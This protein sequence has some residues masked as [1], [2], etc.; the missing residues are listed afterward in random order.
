MFDPS[1]FSFGNGLFY[2]PVT[3]S[4]APVVS[5]AKVKGREYSL[6]DYENLKYEIAKQ[7][8][9]L[10]VNHQASFSKSQDEI[11]DDMA[12]QLASY[13]VSSLADLKENKYTVEE[14]DPYY[15]DD[16]EAPVVTVEKKDVIN[17]KTGEVI[18]LNELNNAAGKGFTWY[19]I[20]FV[21]G[22]AV[23]YAW[24]E[25]TGAGA[26]GDQIQSIVSIPPIA[27]AL[28][29]ATAGA[30]QPTAKDI[31]TSL[32]PE[33]ASQAAIRAATNAIAN[34]GATT[35]VV[36]TATGDLGQGLQAGAA[37]LLQSGINQLKNQGIN[38]L[39]QATGIDLSVPKATGSLLDTGADSTDYSFLDT[40]TQPAP[41]VAPVTTD[42][43]DFNTDVE[44]QV[45]G[46]YGNS[47]TAEYDPRLQGTYL[48]V[49]GKDVFIP[50]VVAP[51]ES[52]IVLSTTEAAPSLLDVAPA[53]IFSS[54]LSPTTTPTLTVVANKPTVT[55]LGAVLTSATN[56]G[57][58]LVNASQP[59][60]GMVN[61]SGTRPGET[62]TFTPGTVEAPPT[63]TQT[64]TLPTVT[65]LV[66]PI[67]TVTSLPPTPEQP[68]KP[69]TETPET[70][71]TPITP[72]ITLPTLMAEPEQVSR[73]YVPYGSVSYEPL[74][75]LLAPRLQTLP[76]ASAYR[77]GLL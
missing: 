22:Q 24:K 58:V 66:A 13:G 27:A 51:T 4:V 23:P 61:I 38:A 10:G 56:L 77:R 73:G 76:Y 67:T 40:P 45:G 2:N 34:A 14:R 6:A 74:L 32:L 8:N 17:S 19:N 49:N 48:T 62:L 9:I 57:D 47:P 46:F 68:P 55:D 41:V 52:P 75:S 44:A 54:L 64:A 69:P 72:N 59:N 18:P 30:L 29:A 36:S 70:P 43:T 63:L 12:K 1:F 33:G 65:D 39:E 42:V 15:F 35:T 37:V 20:D 21:D 25:A 31:A 28:T 50:N 3:D 26:L 7:T 53:P 60:L 5:T 16:G 71:E 11:I